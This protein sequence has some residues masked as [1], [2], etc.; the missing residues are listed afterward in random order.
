MLRN[1]S[2]GQ[3]LVAGLLAATAFGCSSTPP[4]AGNTSGTTTTGGSTASSTA[5]TP[6]G[7]SGPVGTPTVAAAPDVG[8]DAAK[9]QL[10][11]ADVKKL[12]K[13]PHAGDLA[14]TEKGK[15]LFAQNCATCHGD[16]GEGDGPAGAA[17]DPKPRNQ[18]A[19]KEYK[20]GYGELG[21][22]RTVKYGTK[23]TGMAPWQGRMTDDEVWDVV[24]YVRFIQK[25]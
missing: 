3:I 16:K 7:A 12:G 11:Y 23:G 4:T 17:L 10:G 19:P 1:K 18:T 25:T 6:G 20:Y 14:A 5:P 21:I 2:F 13:N 9:D 8:F 24:N 22:F 15:A